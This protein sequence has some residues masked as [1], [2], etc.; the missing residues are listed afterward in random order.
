MMEI[1]RNERKSKKPY[2]FAIIHYSK[3][4]MQ[5][6]DKFKQNATLKSKIELLIWW[7]KKS[8]Y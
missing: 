6:V 2:F 5:D 3:G 4:V 7:R 1:D 8:R